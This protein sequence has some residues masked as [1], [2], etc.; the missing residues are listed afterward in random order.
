MAFTAKIL[1]NGQVATTWATLYAP[2]A[3]TAVAKS[4]TLHNTSATVQTVELAVLPS[5][6]TRRLIGRATLNQHETWDRLTD[7]EIITLGPSD[8]LQAQTTTTTVVD[9]LVTGAEG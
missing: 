3:I 2:S 5:G 1:N 4:V 9:Y 8:A 6:G 7:G